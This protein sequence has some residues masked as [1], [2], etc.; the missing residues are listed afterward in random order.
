MLVALLSKRRD[1]VSQRAQ[2]LINIL[3]FPQSFFISPS[4]TG[5]QPLAASK[6]DQIQRAFAHLAGVC[7]RAANA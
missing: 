3:R 6:V 5:I 4:A 1:D 2:A 7:I